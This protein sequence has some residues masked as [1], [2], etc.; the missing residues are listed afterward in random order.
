[1]NPTFERLIQLLKE[2][3]DRNA[4]I[5]DLTR[6]LRDVLASIRSIDELRKTPMEILKKMDALEAQQADALKEA[7]AIAQELAA[8]QPGGDDKTPPPVKA[9]DVAGQFRSLMD[10][11]QSDART[12]REGEVATTLK[13]LDI[14]L[15]G[16]IVVQNN[17]AQI[18][19]PPPGSKVDPGLLSTIRMSFGTIP[20]LRQ[21]AET[22]PP[23][24][25]PQPAPAPS[26][27]TPAP[28]PTPGPRPR[29]RTPRKPK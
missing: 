4:A 8:S 24:P 19:P 14:E 11:I 29:G 18:A 17:E 21:A 5:I 15:K 13:S 12:P 23:T 1:M 2:C 25:A 10:S 3:S 27:F 9:V 20:V 6:Q 7:L 16:L 22:P 28:T 26:P